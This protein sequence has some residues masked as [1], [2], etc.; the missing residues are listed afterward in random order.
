MKIAVAS[1]GKDENARISMTAGRAPYYIIAED[2]K[3]V[4]VI[5]NPF[6]H[7]GGRAGPGVAEILSK[8]G[9]ELVVAGNIGPNMKMALQTKG[10]RFEEKTGIVKDVL[11]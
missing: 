1:E 5:S 8:E 9:V 3:I 10:I 6:F 4:K 11:R 7:G 2:E